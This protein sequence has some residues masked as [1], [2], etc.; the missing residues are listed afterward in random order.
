MPG[1]ASRFTKFI[2]T[3]FE[4]WNNV[5]NFAAGLLNK[6]G[7]ILLIEFS[8]RASDGKGWCSCGVEN[9]VTDVITVCHWIR[10]RVGRVHNPTGGPLVI[11]G[12]N[13]DEALFIEATA[14]IIEHGKAQAE[15]Y[16]VIG[17]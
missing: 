6:V 3:S 8:K 11:N 1:N 5:A 17:A 4:W 15:F 14:L 13:L 16:A 7:E 10:F 2:F 9:W 12:N